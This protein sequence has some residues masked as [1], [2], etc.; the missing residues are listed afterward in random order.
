MNADSVGIITDVA[1]HDLP[2]NAWSGG[3]NVRFV[4]RRVEKMRGFQRA[5]VPLIDANFLLPVRAPAGQFWLY[6]GE[7]NVYAYGESVHTDITKAGFTYSAI[8]QVWTGGSLNG[9]PILNNPE[10]PPQMWIPPQPSQKMTDLAN[11][12]AGWRCKSLRPFKYYLVALGT[13]K[14]GDA[15]PYRVNWSHPADPGQVPASWDITDPTKDAGET[16]LADTDG[17]LVD[18]LPL[19]GRNIIYKQ[20]SAYAMQHIGGV[21]IFGF[22]A[23]LEEGHGLLV[24]N[25]VRRFLHN[26]QFHLVFGPNDIYTHDGQTSNSILR[27]R[28]RDWLFNNL[29]STNYHRSF[30]AHN[31]NMQEMLICFPQTGA[32]LPDTAIVWNY[33]D[34][35]TTIKDLEDI[36]FMEAGR[37]TDLE[38]LGNDTWDN[39][40]GTWDEDSIPW[41]QGEY[42]A[43]N[44]RLLSI[45]HS[46]ERFANSHDTGH[47]YH[48]AAYES[49]V[50]RLGLNVMGKDLQGNPIFDSDMV[51]IVTEVWPRVRA[52]AGTV[53]DVYVG[54]QM[55]MDDPIDWNGPF[56]FVVGQDEKVNPYC[57]GKIISVRFSNTSTT[58]WDIAGYDLEMQPGGKY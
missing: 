36:S 44:H 47:S 13:T 16:V 17:S 52:N 49:Y 27:G 33:K 40:A 28:M 50:E 55:K 32:A 43:V 42:A 5:F 14:G 8:G 23:I 46:P 37:I 54:T 34:N 58:A 26:G 1:P 3:Q 18:Q 11:W 22:E 29:D 51:K 57:S 35:S 39:T 2:L 12:P 10:D 30:I 21:D 6:A 56:P 19:R 4:N 7:Q 24:P 48:G 38:G 45:G 20:D 53:I 25:G 41:G 31:I 15:N 9:V